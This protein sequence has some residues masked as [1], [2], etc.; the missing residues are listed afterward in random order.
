[1]SS[2]PSALIVGAGFGLSASL[3]RLL[4]REGYGLHL[5]ARNI[6]KLGDLASETGAVVHET[7]AS[8]PDQVAALFDAIDEALYVVVYNPSRRVRGPVTD[9]DPEEVRQAI[10]V[11]AFGAFLVGQQAARRMLAQ[12]PKN[13]CR[14][15]ILFTGASAGVKGFPQSATFAMGKFA[16]RGL[17]QSMSRES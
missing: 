7:D 9:V 12:K 1:M 15:T 17:S 16:Q 13:G 6:S 5:A 14:G 4:H 2:K 3:A 8:Q 11:T 10:D